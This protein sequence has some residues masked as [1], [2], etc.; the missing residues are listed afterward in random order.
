MEAVLWALAIAIHAESKCFIDFSFY[1]KYFSFIF[2]I[3]YIDVLVVEFNSEPTEVDSIAEFKQKNYRCNVL[4]LFNETNNV[5]C[6]WFSVFLMKL[7]FILLWIDKVTLLFAMFLWTSFS[8]YERVNDYK[9]HNLTALLIYCSR[10][11]K[12]FFRDILVLKKIIGYLIK[13]MNAFINSKKALRK[14]RVE[15]LWYRV[16]VYLNLLNMKS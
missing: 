1:F 10:I 14:H 16:C 7:L 5:L 6:T 13:P 3:F 9:I 2:F 12:K 11:K 15:L 8:F 4:C